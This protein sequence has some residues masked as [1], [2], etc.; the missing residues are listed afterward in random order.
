ML[1]KI[2]DKFK[3]FI[4][5]NKIQLI[6]FFLT[7]FLFTYKLPFYIDIPGGL[8]NTDK[9]VSIKESYD[10]KGS[11]NMTYV[12]EIHATPI[13]YLASLILDDWDIIKEEE[14]TYDSMS[15]ED[16]YNYQKLL[17]KETCNNAIINAYNKANKE[18]STKEE[19][20]LVGLV[21]KEAETNLKIA[22]KIISIDGVK[23]NN[24]V[25][26]RNYLNTKNENDKINISVLRKK[27][28]LKI[29]ATLKKSDD[30]VV[31][32][33]GIIDSKVIDTNPKVKLSFDD[34][35]SGPS[36]GLMTALTIYNDLIKEDLTDGDIISG[37]GTIELDGTV[38]EISGV[39]YKILGAVKKKAKVF[40]VPS[41]D[42][43]NEAMKI[44]KER[45]LDIEVVS[46]KTFDDAIEYLRNRK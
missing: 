5:K 40:L 28:E 24:S 43:Y 11:F 10:T 9:R 32:G 12:T 27:K 23:I 18:V 6:V 22:D 1:N 3:K 30:R 20:L 7:I 4:K 34:N 31:I 42:N 39:K 46:I 26:L 36:G 25:D 38:G 33:I 8:I 16:I 19:E 37:T 15:V 29:E 2:Y 45:K 21:F 35:E 44:K 41:G 14:L 13:T 17:L